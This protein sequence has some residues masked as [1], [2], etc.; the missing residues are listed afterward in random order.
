MKL[1]WDIFCNVIDNYGDIG[2]CW[3]LARQLAAEHGCAVRLWVDDLAPFARLCPGLDLTL[4]SQSIGGVA[5]RKWRIPFPDALPADVVIEAFGCKLPDNYRTA[6]AL[7]SSHPTWINLEYLSAEAWVTGTHG[8]PSP[9]PPL[10]K[11]FFFPGFTADTGGLLREHDLLA[12]RDEF[13]G[14]R[15]AKNHFWHSIAVPARR[16]DEIRVSL[17]CYDNPW[18]ENLLRAWVNGTRSITCV[19]PQGVA[20][21][22]LTA[23]FGCAPVVGACHKQGKLTLHVMP[24]LPQER[25]DYLLWACDVNFVRGE[26][27]FVRAQWAARPFVW[28][29]YPQQ[30]DVHLTKLNAFLDLYC[31]DFSL[32]NAQQLRRFWLAWNGQG[33]VAIAWPGFA[34]ALGSL[35]DHTNRWTQQL[36]AQGDLASNLA[37]F[38]NNLVKS[39]VST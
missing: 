1:S 15:A 24:F 30:D 8:L 28:Q 38:C 19:V 34:D 3:R 7:R 37:A 20:T 27:S 11:Y 16:D 26:D 36:V 21:Q 33:D 13:Q 17:F 10:T 18:I 31:H 32:P 9:M 29:I 4:E 2:V 39:R 23:W 25:Y 35:G 12:S 5:V 22:A 6:M 14:D